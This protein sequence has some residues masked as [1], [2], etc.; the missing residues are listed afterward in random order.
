MKQIFKNIE[1]SATDKQGNSIQFLYPVDINQDISEQI[2]NRAKILLNTANSE[3][4]N[5]K[6]LIGLEKKWGR[7]E[8]LKL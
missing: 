2:T 5:V 3:T 1:C 6:V 8:D 4:L 7:I